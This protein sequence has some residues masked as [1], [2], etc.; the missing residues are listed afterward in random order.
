MEYLQRLRG[1]IL[2]F[3]LWCHLIELSKSDSRVEVKAVPIEWTSADAQARADEIDDRSLPELL[4]APPRPELDWLKDELRPENLSV[5]CGEVI[6]PADAIAVLA[7]LWLLHGFSEA[8]HQCSQSIEDGGRR[9]CGN[10]WHAIMHRQEP[11]YGNSKYWFRRVGQHPIFPELAHRAGELL[12]ADGSESAR[13]WRT[14]LGAPQSWNA[15]AFVDWC[16]RA[17]RDG[18]VRQ[19]H[20]IRRIQFVEMQ[21]LLRASYADAAHA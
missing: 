13:H 15:S 20:L 3:P 5:L 6:S 11:D 10:Y 14:K 1:G 7:G 18:D 17:A 4:A 8:S 19:V 9:R 12:E 16:E 21:L 2:S